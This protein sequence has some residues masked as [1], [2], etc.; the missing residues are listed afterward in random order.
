M[1][2]KPKKNGMIKGVVVG[3]VLVCLV[4]GYYFYLSNKDRSK[5]DQDVKATLVQETLM[6]NLEKNYPPTPKEVLKYYGQLTQC[7]Y[8]ET[9]T[10]EEFRELALQAQELYDDELVAAQTLTQYLGSLE[11]DVSTFKDQ[12]IVVSSFATSYSTDVDYFPADGFDWARLYGTFTLRKGT[13]LASSEEV[14]LM[15]KDS[16]GHW[17]IYGWMLAS[18]MKNNAENN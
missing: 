5:G 1:Q 13:Q 11:W 3:L 16:E 10:D 6:R 4:L 12:E 9:Y 18:D 14:F 17:K 15:R 8:N 2:K 7:L